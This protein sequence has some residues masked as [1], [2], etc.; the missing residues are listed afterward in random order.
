[1]T[2]CD[3]C[4]EELK[5]FSKRES[6]LRKAKI[7]VVALSVDLPIGFS[8]DSAIVVKANKILEKLSFPFPSGFAEA[9]LISHLQSINNNMTSI[10]RDLPVPC[11]LLVS[12][13]GKVTAIYKGP[14]SVDQLVTDA[15]KVDV[16]VHERLQ[17][18]MSL[19]GSLVPSETIR[20]NEIFT[21]AGFQFYIGR[22]FFPDS[23]GVSKIHFT[24]ALRI[25]P[26]FVEPRIHLGIALN[27]LNQLE[28]AEQHL[29]MALSQHPGN[30]EKGAAHFQLSEVALRYGKVE[31]AMTHLEATVKY[32][33]D[34]AFALNNLAFL[35]A[36]KNPVDFA[37]FKRAVELA[38]RAVAVT[39]EM[40][41][42]FLD[43]LGGICL[44]A[45]RCDEALAVFEKAL[46]LAEEQE[47]EAL[48]AK[49]RPKIEKSREKAGST[50]PNRRG[51]RQ[52]F[53]SRPQ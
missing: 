39:K 50:P 6:A 4:R 34:Q 7:D 42:N 20:K 19:D 37:A 40:H 26:D 49:L 30:E 48:L 22:E 27:R 9:G 21:E 46:V 41:P 14:V 43:T 2:W 24:E 25:K 52:D 5:E 35:L 17:N 32:D 38:E 18:A 3:L 53:L 12:P 8:A 33:P 29:Q 16:P 36:S 23:P 28:A 51:I 11:S 10:N 15:A 47:K 45:E 31:E 13:L 1:M 44:K